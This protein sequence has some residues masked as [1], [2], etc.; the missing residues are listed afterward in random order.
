MKQRKPRKAKETKVVST[1]EII[2]ENDSSGDEK[3][4]KPKIEKV[5]ENFY[6]SNLCSFFIFNFLTKHSKNQQP[7]K[8]EDE[9]LVV[10]KEAK[11]END[12]IIDDK[13]KDKKIKKEKKE[14]KKNK[15][16]KQSGPMHFTANNEPRALDVLG[17]LDPSIF[18]EVFS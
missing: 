6:I 11:E 14:G 5:S 9:P 15:K 1:K 16:I 8:K 12:V 7:V 18:N 10:K 17:D 2:E 4:H 3:K 13:K